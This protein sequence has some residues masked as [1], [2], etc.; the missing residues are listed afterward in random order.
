MP[1]ALDGN[2]D[3]TERAAVERY[4]LTDSKKTFWWYFAMIG[5]FRHSLRV[6]F[7]LLLLCSPL[8]SVALGTAVPDTAVLLRDGDDHRSLG[9]FI[10]FLEDK[11][12]KLTY[13]DV[14]SPRFAA[15]FARPDREIPNWGLGYTVVWLRFRIN[16]QSSLAREWLLEQRY[17]LVQ[18]FD[19][20]I[21]GNAGTYEVRK[22]AADSAGI[23]KNLPHR[24]PLFSLPLTPQTTTFHIRASVGSIVTFPLIIQTRDYFLSNNSISLLG[25]GFYCG[26]LLTIAIYNIYL[27]VL[28][29]DRVYLYFV[30]YIVFFTLLQLSLH[31][32]V[33]QYLLPDEALLDNYVMRILILVS[34]IASLLFSRRFLNLKEHSPVVDRCLLGLIVAD[35]ILIPIVVFLPVLQSLI[36]LN[37]HTIMAPLVATTA[38]AVS[39]YAGFKPARYYLVARGVF[40]ISLCIFALNN[41]LFRNHDFISWYGMMIGSL[42]EVLLLS[43]ALAERISVALQEKK[44]VEAEAIKAGGR[45]LI[46]EM[47]AGVAHE[48]N[49]P[50]AGII[51]C[52][53]GVITCRENDPERVALI[54]AVDNGLI[55]IRDTIANLLNYSRMTELNI[56]PSSIPVMIESVL[57]LCRYQLG[58][59]NEL[60]VYAVCSVS[61]TTA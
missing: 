43:R 40:Y 3:K 47:A 58:K 16:D 31:G 53:K 37:F 35:T 7:L 11:T 14:T 22:F 50:L 57:C 29:R 41:I 32:F 49:N 46:G 61:G 20:Y 1:I 28:L 54:A 38:G 5:P 55:K 23:L 25:Y 8:P 59:A 10:E 4:S 60:R 45:V 51:L 44:R 26:L 39:Y 27:F 18:S 34:A 48:V 12:G 36:I 42:F 13:P 17:P 15:Q 2:D 33:R 19:L 56:N 9:P 21:P 30:A 6:L 24:N 52:F